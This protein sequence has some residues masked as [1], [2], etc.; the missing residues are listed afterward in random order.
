MYRGVMADMKFNCPGC[1]QP[2]GCDVLWGG[3]IIECP[4]CKR[5]IT[6]PQQQAAPTAAPVQRDAA[7]ALVPRPPAETKLSIG[8]SKHEAASG[9]PAAAK[10]PQAQRGGPPGRSMGA[11]GKKNPAMKYLKIAAVVIVVGVAVYFG[12]GFVSQ[13]Q[14][15]AN[16]KR[17]QAEK[18][19][20]GGEVGHIGALYGALDATEPGHALGGGMR[21]S[22]P[23][24]RRS[25]GPRAIQLGADGKPMPQAAAGA[26]LPVV[27]PEFTL[28]AATAQIPESPV[29]GMISGTNFV[30]ET[31]RIDFVAGAQVLRLIQGPIAA[32]DREILIYLHPKPG[33]SLVGHKWNV[34]K[35]VKSTDVSQV[36]KRWKANPRVAPQFKAY[37]TGYALKL[38]L[39]HISGGNISGKVF[40]A[41]PDPENSVAAG[42]FNAKTILVE[43][44]GAGTNS[45]AAT[46]V[47]P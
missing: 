32:P 29:N 36:L 43:P 46:V 39:G 35:D 47:K 31:A 27:A 17:R 8:A 44:P 45:A 30:M 37:T 10:A 13:W 26:A 25:T 19:A 21:G 9:P 12:W 38:E 7:G 16:E 22:T 24:S 33:E 23:G 34:S 3:H 1:G 4:T 18:N 20:D 15:K 5:E 14:E 42:V 28:D 2:I 11:R 41:L 6:V 40:V